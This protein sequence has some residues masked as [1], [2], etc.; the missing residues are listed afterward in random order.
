M[1]TRFSPAPSNF[2][3]GFIVLARKLSW[4]DGITLYN[5]S[6]VELHRFVSFFLYRQNSFLTAS[7]CK[8]MP[9][10]SYTLP[11]KDFYTYGCDDSNENKIYQTSEKWVHFFAKIHFLASVLLKLPVLPEWFWCINCFVH[12]RNLS[13]LPLVIII[14]QSLTSSGICALPPLEPISETECGLTYARFYVTYLNWS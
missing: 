5:S 13:P 8:N 4:S 1:N 12:R 3:V 7:F 2:S 6:P 9:L 11:L 10:L 14:N